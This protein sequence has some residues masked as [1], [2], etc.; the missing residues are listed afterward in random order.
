MPKLNTFNYKEMREKF[1]KSPSVKLPKPLSPYK[2]PRLGRGQQD[3][4][5]VVAKIDGRFAVL[6]PY[7]DESLAYEIGS[8]K[9]NSSFDV[10][11]LPTKDRTRATQIVRHHVLD[12]SGD[13]SLALRRMR[14]SV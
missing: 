8:N 5:Y 9:L 1:Y 6:G 2:M 12:N 13:L 4:F 11:S 14:H 3:Y 10:I 7:S